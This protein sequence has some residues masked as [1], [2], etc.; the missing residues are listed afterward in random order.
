MDHADDECP[1]TRVKL[2][3]STGDITQSSAASSDDSSTSASSPAEHADGIRGYFESARWT[4]DGTTLLTTTSANVVSAYVL[5]S[6]LLEPHAA[7]PLHLSATSHL[8]LPEPSNALAGAPYFSLGSAWTQQVLVSARDHPLQLFSISSPSSPPAASYPL[9]KARGEDFLS[10]ASLAWPAPGQHFVAGAR[11]LLARFD[12]G[13]PG[14]GPVVRLPTI[15]SERHLSKGGGV[16]MRGVVSALA[17][18]PENPNMLA[19]G[20]WTRWAGLYDFAQPPRSAAVATWSVRSAAESCVCPRQDH[21]ESETNGIGGAGITQTLWSPCGRFL[22]VNERQASGLLVYD[23]RVTGQLLGWL[24]G[25]A[26]A[27]NQRTACDVFPSPAGFEVWAGAGDGTVAV[28]DAVGASEGAQQPSSRWPAHGAAV[29]SACL[30]PTGSVVVTCAGSWEF[31]AEC[32][33]VRVGMKSESGS[34]SGS[35]SEDSSDGEDGWMP[36]MRRRNRESSLKIWGIS[37]GDSEDG[38]AEEAREEEAPPP[39]P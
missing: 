34:G 3:A 33:S 12:A 5:P 9:T 22:L 8:R 10:A 35:G 19:A 32:E 25:R 27:G 38:I 24:A 7:S 30:H 37:G 2:V 1:E 20:T 6:D 11:N 23:V 13:R 28:W 36:W 29:G 31:P 39:E 18:A 17:A 15:P 4:A 21:E 16:G 14:D 26:P